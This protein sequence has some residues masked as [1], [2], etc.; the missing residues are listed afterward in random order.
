MKLAALALACALIA[1]PAVGEE[2]TAFLHVN[3]APMT[4]E[5]VLR[6][7]TLIVRDGAI[8]AIGKDLPPPPGAR[9][10]DGRG[11]AW[12][13]PGLVDGHVHSDTPEALKVYLAHGITSVIDMGAARQEFISQVMPAVN[14]GKRPGPHV[15]AALRV[16]G[17][18]RYGQ[19]VV[20]DAEDARAAVRL[21][22]ANGYSF[23]KVYNNLAPATFA[24]LAQ[25]G[26]EQRLPLVGHGV[27][28][29][30]LPAQLAAGQLLVAH[31]EEF[32]YT[33]PGVPPPDGAPSDAAIPAVVKLVK[34]AGAFV[35]ADLVTYGAIVD[36]WGKPDRLAGYLAA[37]S[38]SLVTPER[39]IEWKDSGYVRR[40]GDITPNLAF[41]ERL[42]LA[43]AKAGVP[44]VAGTD[45]PT[46]P[47]LVPGVSLHDD[48]ARL[49]AAG[50]SPYQTLASATRTPGE[51]VA[52]ARAD[53][54]RFGVLAPGAR[55][56]LILTARNPLSDLSTL[57]RP[58]G[59]MAAGRWYEAVELRAMLD[60]VA[61]T[62]RLSIQ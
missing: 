61:A 13:A 1:G 45:A 39:R 50:L 35:G 38:A 60:E 14:A 52:R 32:L 11:E 42:A 37:P 41:L 31:L 15:Y 26:R 62:Y 40:T 4:S 54:P 46:V 48:L 36:Q 22:K 28:A 55:A 43:L 51:L 24:A 21:A 25:A 20:R 9:V 7:Q 17:S 30:G 33:G 3:L 59:V 10:I 16:D 6:D 23:I 53:E 56:D 8:A 19:L 58:Q 44:L 18:P 47:G 34:D 49:R 29:V 12:L 2:V 57:R 27:T 5:A